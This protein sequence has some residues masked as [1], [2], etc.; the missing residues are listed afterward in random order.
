[1]TLFLDAIFHSQSPGL[2]VASL[3][4]STVFLFGLPVLAS[5]D[6][7]PIKKPSSFDSII[8]ETR[9]LG[10]HIKLSVRRFP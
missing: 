5:G 2:E 4:N 9:F 1:M 6:L 8:L 10:G 7:V 3:V